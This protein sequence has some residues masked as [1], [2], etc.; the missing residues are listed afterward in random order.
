[1][2]EKPTVEQVCAAC[3]A[4]YHNP[5]A[6]S[7]NSASKW[8][9]E[10]QKTVLAWEV[11]DHCLHQKVPMEVL[12]FASQTIRKKIQYSF[13]DLP[14]DARLGLRESLLSNVTNHA[15]STPAVTTQLS[16]AVADLAIQM[17]RE[18]S[19]S[20]QDLVTMLSAQPATISCLL[21]ILAVLPEEIDNEWLPLTMKERGELRYRFGFE[22][23]IIYPFIGDCITKYSSNVNLLSKA[24][25][26]LASWLRFGG[27][28]SLQFEQSPLLDAC[29]HAV[30]SEANDL[31]SAGCKALAAACFLSGDRTHHPTLET[32]LAPRILDLRSFVE[33][34]IADEDAE[35]LESLVQVLTQ[36]ADT[37]CHA[38]M[39]QPGPQHVAMLH[40]MT[41]ITTQQV[42]ADIATMTFNFWY[43]LSDV[44]YDAT[45][46][47]PLEFEPQLQAGVAKEL[48]EE[49][50]KSGFRPYFGELFKALLQHVKCN[51]T[52][53]GP[54]S[55]DSTNADLRERVTDL[56]AETSFVVGT[57]GL[58]SLFWGECQKP[59]ARWNDL[60]ANLF[61]M[62]TVAR[63]ARQDSEVAPHILR[64]L[65]TI[66]PDHHDQLYITVLD[67]YGR[68]AVWSST[69]QDGEA[70]GIIWQQLVRALSARKHIRPVVRSL[71][72]LCNNCRSKIAPFFDELTSIV[73]HA[74]ALEIPKADVIDII[75]GGSRVASH[76]PVDRITA[77]VTAISTPILE[78][79]TKDINAGVSPV[80]ALDR[81]ASLFKNTNVPEA[82]VKEHAAGPAGVHPLWPV[83]Q[84]V[85]PVL[86]AVLERYAGN[87]VVIEEGN[88]CI[89]YIIRGLDTHAVPLAAPIMEQVTKL[90]AGHKHSSCLYVAQGLVKTFGDNPEFADGMLLM[91]R[92]LS[93]PT[94]A[95]LT[96]GNLE[97]QLVQNPEIVDD[98]LRLARSILEKAPGML[99]ETDLGVNAFQLG[100]AAMRLRH[101]DAHETTSNFMRLYVGLW[102]TDGLHVSKEQVPAIKQ[103]LLQLIDAYGEQLVGNIIGAATGD[104]PTMYLADLCDVLFEVHLLTPDR[105]YRFVEAAMGHR[106][107][108]ESR[109]TPEQKAEFLGAFSQVNDRLT[110]FSDNVKR[111][112]R[113]VR[114]VHDENENDDA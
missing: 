103:Y 76:M 68:L 64:A 70:A 67:L 66:G 88:R 25:K 91:F 39:L 101:R 45:T 75:K 18:W 86:S 114:N 31:V 43:N 71:G 100:S 52:L 26:C 102:R 9:E 8:L 41:I 16:V 69:L 40:I 61:M 34:A 77:A 56:M 27:E 50:I 98:Y 7:K 3:T 5:D 21:D 89:K 60:E 83:V 107:I 35:R 36:L 106:N 38:S 82:R 108:A 30:Q 23:T 32:T 15:S 54:L 4:L 19:T 51:E 2:S 73:V 55:V 12:F 46:R 65:T 63:N 17:M 112:G 111:F 37:F 6:Q 1:M 49:Q 92:T 57:E 62:S 33:K 47:L 109:A 80:T 53:P 110:S 81:L 96:S 28:G 90:F 95:T 84:T 59:G 72:V 78:K 99:L 22:S 74:D 58:L 94:F 11:A 14:P 42:D 10:L 44:I 48:I 87:N 113:F 79:L 105:C 13:H 29:F 20:I 85:F 24:F 104:L 93:A 97:E